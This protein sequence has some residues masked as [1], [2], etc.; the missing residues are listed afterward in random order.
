[1]DANYGPYSELGGPLY[2]DGRRSVNESVVLDDVVRHD[3]IQQQL[4][5]EANSSGRHDRHSS[6]SDPPTP[7]MT[8]QQTLNQPRAPHFSP[9]YMTPG[10]GGMTQSTNP[11]SAPQSAPSSGNLFWQ[12]FNSMPYMPYQGG[13]IGG[14]RHHSIE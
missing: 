7:S 14:T 8:H 13:G 1:M 5:E 11:P 3:A 12:D 10:L 2:Q 9:R 4:R 6:G